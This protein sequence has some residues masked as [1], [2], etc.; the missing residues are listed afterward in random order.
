MKQRITNALLVVALCAL[1]LL[2]VFVQ[3]QA[4]PSTVFPPTQSGNTYTYSGGTATAANA[5]SI[6]FPS[7][8]NGPVYGQATQS[9]PIGGGRTVPITVRSRPTAQAVA[10]AVGTFAGKIATPLVVG[11]ALWDLCNELGFSCS[12]GSDGKTAVQAP[13]SA[14]YDPASKGAGAD[15]LPYCGSYSGLGFGD[16]CRGFPSGGTGMVFSYISGQ[17]VTDLLGSGCQWLSNNSP[18]H[19]VGCYVTSRPAA[20]VPKTVQDLENAIASKSGWPDGSAISR[21]LPEAIA[22]GVP[23]EMPSPY[24]ITGPA[25]VPLSPTVT[26]WPDGSKVTDTPTKNLQYGPNSVTVTE[27]STKTS[28]DPSG[29]TSPV[30]TTTTNE[31]LPAP[32]EQTEPCGLPDTPMC[33]IDGAG[34]PT[35]EELPNDQAEKSLNPVKDFLQNP[36]SVIPQLPT[37]NWAFALPTACGVVPLP[38]FAPFVEG[39]DVC[40]FQPMFHEIMSVVWMLGALFGAISLFMRSSLAD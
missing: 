7:P 2:P 31:P 21:V 12:M 13:A 29:V 8:A 6:S 28:T 1:F 39:V 4:L 3:A 25:S 19:V 26:T 38:A 15:A 18:W 35:A 32:E 5:S 24:E 34:T 17:I 37:I 16:S 10:K 33:A 36:F 9:Q 14:T 23:L 40:Q 20:M 30:S 27:T 22:S 11:V